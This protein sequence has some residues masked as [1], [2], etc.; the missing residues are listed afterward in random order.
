MINRKEYLRGAYKCLRGLH[1]IDLIVKFNNK[2]F[3]PFTA[4]HQTKSNESDRTQ[5]CVS[6]L[7]M[8]FKGHDM[9]YCSSSPNH[10]QIFSNSNN[11]PQ[12]Q[13]IWNDSGYP[14]PKASFVYL[15][16]K[17]SLASL[18]WPKSKRLP[19]SGYFASFESYQEVEGATPVISTMYQQ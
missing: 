15:N 7:T 19:P 10:L 13:M 17:P 2:P 11:P 8:K 4:K 18:K 14:I 6:K 12:S 9:E 1:R 16:V 5:K 3:Q